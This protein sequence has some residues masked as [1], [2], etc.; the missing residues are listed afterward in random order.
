M[1]NLLFIPCY[2]CAPQI[3][4]VLENITEELKFFDEV[5]VID[6]LSPDGT[7]EIALAKINELKLSRIKVLRNP[8]NVGLGGSHKLAF[9]Y[10][11]DN[12]FDHVVILHGD[13]QGSL[14][15]FTPIL[16]LAQ[17]SKFED[18]Q[19]G[20]R[21]HPASRL[22]GYSSFRI[23]GNLIYNALASLL[24]LK[25]IYDLGGSGL[26]LFPVS[27]IK[28]HHFSQYS[29]DL[30][31][32]VFILLNA[33]TLKQR[34]KYIPITWRED[35]QISNVR[36]FNQSVKLL[37]ILCRYFFRPKAFL[38]PQEVDFCYGPSEWKQL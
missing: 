33:F 34:V 29:N 4:R 22:K 15:D 9:Q 26:N 6:N 31:F 37:K 25:K 8:S 14:K 2:R 30:T 17:S 23:F 10:A 3:V 24:S 18:F 7:A 38:E 21:F 19:F 28:R 32:H 11:I 12:H 1:K 13:D 36:L 5:L 16:E 35:D 20:A 27:L